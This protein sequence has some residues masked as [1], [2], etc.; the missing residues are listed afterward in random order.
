[1]ITVAGPNWTVTRNLQ[2]RLKNVPENGRFVFGVAKCN[3]LEQL[4]KMQENRVRCVPFT[5]LLTVAREWVKDGKVVLGRTLDHTQGK[6]IVVNK[7]K[8]TT[9]A[10]WTEFVPSLEEWR[11]HIFDGK[12][13]ARGKKVFTRE[14]PFM[15][16]GHTGT[17][18]GILIRNRANDYRMVHNV[19][20]PRGMREI[21]RQAVAAVGE[22]FGAVDILMEGAGKFRVL[23]VNKAP[24]MDN[25]T[26]EAYVRAIRRRFV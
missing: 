22:E 4:Q 7:V 16:G 1:M 13:I 8:K 20:P 2:E 26:L 14:Q 10:Y 21:A 18:D 24:A 12:S 15:N 9:R 6:D 23:E 25:Y 3:K 19:E 5:N 11:I 17:L